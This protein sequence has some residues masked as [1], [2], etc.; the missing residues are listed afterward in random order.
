MQCKKVKSGAGKV[1]RQIRIAAADY[2]K[3]ET[4]LQVSSD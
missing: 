2:L 1:E 3:L 4:F